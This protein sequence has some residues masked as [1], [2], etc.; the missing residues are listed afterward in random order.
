[1]KQSLVKAVCFFG[2]CGLPLA[3]RD[4]APEAVLYKVRPC[5]VADII[6]FILRDEALVSEANFRPCAFPGNFKDHLRVFPFALVF[7]EVEIVVQ[8]M[9]DHFLSGD[10][11]DDPDPAAMDVFVMIDVYAVELVGDAFDAF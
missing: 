10:E 4:E 1:M 8:D 2:G 3:C 5:F 9:P 6:A 11:L 7:Y